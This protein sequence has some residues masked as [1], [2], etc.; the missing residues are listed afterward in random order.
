MALDLL[1]GP[2]NIDTSRLYVT[3]F[4]GDKVLGLPADLECF[5]IWRSLGFVK[6][7]ESQSI[8]ESNDCLLFF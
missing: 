3:Y 5:E 7:K 2:Y 6:F 4:A 1:K 8:V